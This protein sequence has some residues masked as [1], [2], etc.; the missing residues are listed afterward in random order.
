MVVIDLFYL[1]CKV[2]KLFSCTYASIICCITGIF[3]VLKFSVYIDTYLVS[4]VQL[5]NLIGDDMSTKKFYILL[6]LEPTGQ[7]EA[8]IWCPCL[9]CLFYFD[10]VH[11][12]LRS[13]FNQCRKLNN[14]FIIY[15]Y[16]V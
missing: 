1:F 9:S 11:S 7:F 12:P 15:K 10:A 16:F 14:A 4:T 6:N 13:F 8:N 5:K 2:G 3:R